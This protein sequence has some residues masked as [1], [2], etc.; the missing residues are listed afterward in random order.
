MKKAIS[1]PPPPPSR[2]NWDPHHLTPWRVCPPTF[3][4]GGTL[5]LGGEGVGGPNSD[6]GTD[7][8]YSRDIQ[9]VL[10]DFNPYFDQLYFHVIFVTLSGLFPQVLTTSLALWCTLCINNTVP[11]L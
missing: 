11:H 10:C 3:G 1:L 4:S 9:Y 6:K 7:T 2:P 5:S 8:V